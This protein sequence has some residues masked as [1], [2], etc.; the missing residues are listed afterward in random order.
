MSRV[1]DS[2]RFEPERP[3]N[4]A[5]SITLCLATLV[6][7]TITMAAIAVWIAFRTIA[8]GPAGWIVKMAS[9]PAPGTKP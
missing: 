2:S 6:G 3:L 8:V 4:R 5:F 9:V 1:E 7:V